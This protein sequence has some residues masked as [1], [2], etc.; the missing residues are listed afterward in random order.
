MLSSGL[1]IPGGRHYLSFLLVG[2]N[3]SPCAF[4]EL[5]LPSSCDLQYVGWYES[6]D[7]FLPD[8]LKKTVLLRFTSYPSAR[9]QCQGEKAQFGSPRPPP[10]SG[11]CQHFNPI[12]E[13]NWRFFAP[14]IRCTFARMGRSV[15]A[16]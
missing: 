5:T 12:V 10:I 2:P 4:R 11:P 8:T 14:P 16:G 9:A 7:F 15:G 1:S 6:L 13:K 3:D